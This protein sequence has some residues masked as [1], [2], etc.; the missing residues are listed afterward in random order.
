MRVTAVPR[1]FGGTNLG[2]GGFQCEEWSNGCWRRL[3]RRRYR[4][5]IR[6]GKSGGVFHFSFFRRE[7]RMERVLNRRPDSSSE[8]R[9]QLGRSYKLAKCLTGGGQRFR[10]GCSA[11]LVVLD[12]HDGHI[13]H[14]NEVERRS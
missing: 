6:R 1:I 4:R 14:A 5:D 13:R 9:R 11:M 2:D 12:S 8:A 10:Q 3:V 7:Q